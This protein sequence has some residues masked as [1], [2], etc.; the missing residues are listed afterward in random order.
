MEISHKTIIFTV[1]FL[2][3]LWFVY[4]IRSVVLLLFVS[5]VLMTALCPIVNAL[6]KFKLPRVLAIFL[7]FIF[8]IILFSLIVAGIVPALVEQSI[9]LANTVSK[10]FSS[11]SFV[12][13]D[14]NYLS[15]QLELVSKSAINIFKIILGL[16][17]NVITVLT[18]FVFTFYLLMEREK[19]P[20]YL[21]ILFNDKNKQKKYEDLLVSIEHKMGGWVRGELFLMLA[22]GVL[23]Y[24]GLSMFRIPYA[25]PLALLAGL[26]E[27]IPNLGPTLAMIPAVLVGLTISPMLA[28][29]IAIMY[30]VIQQLENNLIVPFVMKKSVGL[31]PLITLLSL[32][33]GV[34]IGGVMGAILAVP[35]FITGAILLK[36]FYKYSKF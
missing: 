30:L 25:L 19:F 32:M 22:I 4:Q 36:H 29:G 11:Y 13:W 12:Q 17:S 28:G 34:T 2:L 24:L 15:S 35:I 1:L 14:I 3:G 6:Q 26:L 27:L 10:I 20:V 18:L 9:N 8:V 16:G 33:I 5:F 23:T 21:K 31:N 7:T